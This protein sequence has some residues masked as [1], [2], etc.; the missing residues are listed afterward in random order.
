V[1]TGDPLAGAAVAAA[2]D[3]GSAIAAAAERAPGGVTWVAER[4][5]GLKDG[6][7]AI[8]TGDVGESLYDGAAGIAI[9]LAACAGA[10]TGARAAAL[11]AAAR[12]GAGRALAGVPR[13][14][15]TGRLGLFD[16]ATG[17]ALAAATVGRALGDEALLAN[18]AA[19]AETLGRRTSQPELDV[20]SGVAGT[21][22]GLQ[23]VTVLLGRPAPTRRLASGARELAAA[24]EP[25]VW[26]AAWPVGDD[27]PLL[28]LAHG[29]AG[30]ALALGEVAAL[31]FEP[32][33]ARACADAVAYERGHFDAERVAWPDLRDAGPGGAPTGWMAAWCH[34]A[35]GIGLSR[36][37]LATLAG[38][39]ELVGEA[40]AAL[41]A[42]RDL[43]VAEGTALRAGRTS[44]CSP[45][46]GLAGAVELLLVA[47]RAL[48]VPDHRRAASRVVALM[49]EQREAAGGAWPCGLP[50]AGEVPALM[51]GGAGIALTLLRA[52]GAT[53]LAT[54]LLPGPSGW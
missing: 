16:G 6:R 50:G 2:L 11:A 22:L 8:D 52:A 25:Q 23:G 32:A 15:D 34:G 9:G 21:L 41:Q 37:R 14:L 1:S 18:A 36:L 19:L 12:G 20:V 24:A 38:D 17:V 35:L 13:L 48:D 33:A 45:C 53:P 46:H 39:P 42:A 29:A 49:L 7:A 31:G 26:G 54:P 40:T 5:A 3:T 30:I 43:V 4:L 28:G 47:A 27:P 44:D 10:A 51:T